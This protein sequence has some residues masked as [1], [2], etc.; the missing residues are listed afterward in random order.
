L[1]NE[2]ATISQEEL[3]ALAADM[4]ASS[5][6][7]AGGG[8]SF[9]P[10]FKVWQEDDSEEDGAPRLK[11]KLYITGQDPFV[12]ADNKTVVTFRPLTQTF[13][14][15]Q[16]DDDN[17]INVNKTRLIYSFKDEAR[18]EKGTLR[19]GKP[20]SK[21]LKD[22]KELQK[23][24]E[25]IKT[26][27][28]LQG[29]VSYVGKTAEGD[30][31]E[32]KDVLVSIN[33]KG[34]SFNAFDEEVIKKMP[35]KSSLWDFASTITTSKEKKGTVTYWVLHYEPDFSVKLPLT[36]ETFNTIKDL[37]EK[38]EATN[39]AI[40]KKYYEA[41]SGAGVDRAAEEAIKGVSSGRPGAN[42][43]LAAD[44]DDDIPF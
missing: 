1:S 38:I 36:I 13:Q 20:P 12:Y 41:K 44:F 39:K 10:A 6:D 42:R 15:R 2:L 31:V 23:K 18:D 34:A 27:R 37:K 17:K 22:N 4:G 14:Y 24:Y 11:G 16:W 21:D 33:S 30:V 8:G 35:D 7:L 43:G 32:V 19:C 3:D 25:D 5:E 28:I 26:F 29:Y 9:L 40:D